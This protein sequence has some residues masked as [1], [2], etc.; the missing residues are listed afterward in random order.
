MSR[1]PNLSNEYWITLW[2]L[3]RSWRQNAAAASHGTKWRR[4]ER[5]IIAAVGG[6]GIP[7][8]E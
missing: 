6:G 3:P 7:E 5:Y 8:D 2:P 4:A 1:T